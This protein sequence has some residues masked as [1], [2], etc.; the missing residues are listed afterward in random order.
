MKKILLLLALTVSFFINGEIAPTAS[1]RYLELNTI[2]KISDHFNKKSIRHSNKKIDFDKNRAFFQSI[3]EN[4][5]KRLIGYH[6]CSMN[7]RI[8]QDIVKAVFEEK[9]DFKDIPID[10]HFLRIPGEKQFNL[11][12]GKFSFIEKFKRNHQKTTFEQKIII[13]E[14]L[15]IKPFYEKFNFSLNANINEDTYGILWDYAFQLGLYLNLMDKNGLGP[16][17]LTQMLS[18]LIISEAPI[19]STP[20][21]YLY[22]RI[23]HEQ[24]PYKKI[25]LKNILFE[26]QKAESSKVFLTPFFNH[27]IYTPAISQIFFEKCQEENLSIEYQEIKTF[28]E[29]IL[30]IEGLLHQF[31]KRSEKPALGYTTFSFLIPFCDI[32]PEQQ[33]ILVSINSSLFGNYFRDDESSLAA[34][35]YNR[36]VEARENLAENILDNFFLKIGMANISARDLFDIAESCLKIENIREGCM[37]QLFDENPDKSLAN[38]I[39]YTSRP[40]GY[41]M[42]Q[43]MPSEI[44][45]GQKK[46][47]DQ[48]GCD[49]QLRM[50]TN[51]SITLNPYSGLRILRYDKLPKELSQLIDQQIRSKIRTTNIDTD[52]KNDYL[53]EIKKLWQT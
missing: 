41:P 3:T 8:F 26:K 34:F 42:P 37:L 50:I 30:S 21:I 11:P 17:L 19:Y 16:E 35:S 24:N 10:F 15:I 13:I 18:D 20:N 39:T 6:G 25:I 43:I 14:D 49:Y 45:M 53:K 38:I 1:F 51:N 27:N 31:W 12:D 48:S 46:E 36:S 2:K 28:F 9:L 23:R 4:E 47:R 5:N 44:I 22:Q 52:K 29:D 7:F 32:N 40:F 33:K